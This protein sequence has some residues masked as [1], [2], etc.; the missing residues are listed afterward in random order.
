VYGNIGARSR[1]NDAVASVEKLRALVADLPFSRCSGGPVKGHDVL[2]HSTVV[3]REEENGPVTNLGP[4]PIL[5]FVR[6]NKKCRLERT[7]P[8]S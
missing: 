5:A 4:L 6:L 8:D 1:A 2:D 3:P 7:C